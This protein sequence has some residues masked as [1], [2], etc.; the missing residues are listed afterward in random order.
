[1]PESKES[2]SQEVETYE[3]AKGQVSVPGHLKEDMQICSLKCPSST[4]ITSA[5]I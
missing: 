3:E 2:A 1:V 5:R 4:A